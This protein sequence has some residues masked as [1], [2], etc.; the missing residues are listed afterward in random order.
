MDNTYTRWRSQVR[1][2]RAGRLAFKVAAALLGGFF[3]V[4][5]LVAIVLPGP[6][7]I[8]PVLLG[9]WIWSTEF[10]WAERLRDRAMDSARDAWETAKKNPVRSA[11]IAGVGI[12]MAIAGVVYVTL[13]VL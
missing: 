1:R 4:L 3:V 7:T 10:V 2:T 6:L 13:K 11:V 5:G 12:L 8:P 9:V